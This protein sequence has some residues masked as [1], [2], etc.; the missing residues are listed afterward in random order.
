MLKRWQFPILAA[1]VLVF[2]VQPGWADSESSATSQIPRLSDFKQPATTV[3]EWLSQTSPPDSS[4]EEEE[5]EEEISV[6]EKRQRGYGVPNSTTGTRTDTPSRDVP[7]SI[8][9][10]PEQVLRD[11]QVIQLDEAVRNVSGVT[12]AGT[13]GGADTNFVIRG[14]SDTPT[15]RD[16]FREF[17]LFR[18]S[19]ETANLERVEVLKGP[20]SVLYGEVQPGGVINLV[21]KQPLSQPF[22]ETE[23]QVGSRDLIRPSIDFSGPL[24]S[25]RRLLYRL[26]AVAL[27]QSSFRNYEQKTQQVFIAPTLSWKISDRT[28]L[29]AQLEYFNSTRPLDNGLVALGN[30]VASIPF[31]RILDEP[32]DTVQEDSVRIGYNLEHRFSDNLILRNAFQYVNRS[33]LNQGAIP[34]E[35]DEATGTLTSFFGSQDIDVES[36]TLQ[37]NLVGKFATG[38]IQHTLLFGVDLNRVNETDLTG[39]DFFSPISKNIFDPIY[40]SVLRP[41]QLPVAIN[42]QQRTNRLGIYLQ[43]QITLSNN[44]KL[45][46]GIRYDTVKQS[47]TSNPTDSS[48]DVSE[49]TQ[50]DNAFTPRVGIVY[51]PIQPLSLYASYS[52]SFAPSSGRT[53]SGG[54]LEPERGEGWEV[55]AKAELLRNRVFATLSYFD[56]TKQNVAT[57]DPND[58]F[59]SIS[60]GEQRSRG[61][62]LDVTGEILPGWNVILG[63]AYTNAKVTR[64]N[65]VAV[66]NRLFNTPE[67]GVNLWT[68]YEIQRGSLR[69]LGFGAGFNY[70]GERQ[71]DLSNSFEL[72]SYFLTNA[73]IFYQRNNLRFALNFKN[74]FNIN[75]IRASNNRRSSGVEPGEPFTVVGSVSLQF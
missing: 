16:G 30:R 59:A 24:T 45:L 34:F 73:A 42:Q 57:A 63:Y 44:L 60:T 8:Q 17:G 50:T 21:T 71:G 32:G 62:E 41:N 70:V 43:D 9:V 39:L 3:Q 53:S 13:S 7:Q 72:E 25:D 69:G 5:E 65:T 68:T 28:N 64:D 51:Q 2:N 23:L 6:T 15:L 35:V 12:S 66:G 54:P 49:T 19:S 40:N 46:A 36:Y 52:R 31:D 47:V 14:F 18:G 22:Y 56:I 48:F 33:I 58:P 4:N 55:G 38:K 10:V 67:H 26:N 20:A 61:V 29:T 11:Q 37:T 74:L 75:Y 27:N 1:G